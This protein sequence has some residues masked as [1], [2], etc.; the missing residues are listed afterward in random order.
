MITIAL[1]IAHS[2]STNKSFN[3]D[4]LY[5]GTLLADAFIIE[6]IAKAFC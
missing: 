3:P 1:L 2:R 5:A 4:L 6:V